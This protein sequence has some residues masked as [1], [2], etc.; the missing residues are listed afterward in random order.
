MLQQQAT[1]RPLSAQQQ[2]QRASISSSSSSSFSKQQQQQQQR[3]SSKCSRAAADAQAARRGALRPGSRRRLGLLP[4]TAPEL[5]HGRRRRAR[6]GP[7]PEWSPAH[8]GCARW[9]SGSSGGRGRRGSSRVSAPASFLAILLLVLR[10]RRAPDEGVGPRPGGE[11]AVPGGVSEGE[12]K[13]SWPEAAVPRR[14]RAELTA[15]GGER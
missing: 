14:P 2:Q 1:N 10:R 5:R 11:A 15:R 4:A 13:R 3:S 7:E 8:R 9:S 12:R 6:R